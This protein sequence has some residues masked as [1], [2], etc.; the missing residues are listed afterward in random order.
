M[1]DEKVLESLNA[2]LVRSVNAEREIFVEH[3]KLR[4][5]Y[6]LRFAIGNLH[7]SETHVRRAFDILSAHAARLSA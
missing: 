3:T 4:D 5:A 2:R 7:T 6:T 1:T